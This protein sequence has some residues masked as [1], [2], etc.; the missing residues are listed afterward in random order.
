MSKL[1]RH[2][3]LPHQPTSKRP[4]RSTKSDTR[5]SDTNLSPSIN[6]RPVTVDPPARVTRVGQN[7]Q[8]TY[9]K[10]LL[11][12]TDSTNLY[13]QGHYNLLRKR[14]NEEGYILIKK[15]IPISAVQRGRDSFFMHLNDRL[16]EQSNNKKRKQQGWTIDAQTGW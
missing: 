14:L 10:D 4:R 1:N 12:L 11:E 6:D 2:S 16:A 3:P 5:N 7:R 9:G 8:V 13:L 15:L